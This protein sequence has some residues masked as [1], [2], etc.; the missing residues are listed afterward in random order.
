MLSRH[1]DKLIEAYLDNRL[2]P[3]ERRQVE[4]HIK[5]CAECADRLF[6]AKRL[7][8]QLGP[9]MQAAL[10]QPVLR[11]MLHHEVRQALLEKE[12]RRPFYLN[13]TAPARFLNAVGTVA[14]IG[15]LAIGVFVV[16]QSQMPSP[17]LIQNAASLQTGNTSEE[18]VRI[19]PSPTQST[20]SEVI[21]TP[22]PTGTSLNDIVSLPTPSPLIPIANDE[23]I[24]V[25][26]PLSIKPND[27]I[28]N[29]KPS[30]ALSPELEPEE[31]IALEQVAKSD[32]PGGTIAFALLN[33]LS[34][35]Q[36]YEIHFINPDGTD[37][38]QFPLG[39]VSEPAL[40]PAQIENPL[41]FRAWNEPTSP[42]SIQS[43]DLEAN[44]P[45]SVTYFWEDA[46]P[47]WSPTEN[48]II[49]ASQ[50]EN[51][52]YWRLYT[53]WGDG[54]LEVNLRREGR[55][56]TFAPDGYRFAFESCD[57]AGN[58]CGLWVGDL[59]N[60]E[61]DSK[62]ILAD[63]LA[64]S[65]DWSPVAEDIAYMA[66]PHGD[67]DLYLVKSDGSNIRQLTYDRA[68]EGLPTWSPDGEWLAF[69]SDREEQWGIW[70]LHVETG[71]LYQTITFA[72]DT[73]LPP[74]RPPYNEQEQRQWWDEQLS[75]GPE[76]GN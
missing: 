54:S 63:P 18:I 9:T 72:D 58:P 48:R 53:V 62:P 76:I 25:R 24:A 29:E 13:W 44:L 49:F 52:R 42:R 46:Q 50:R 4:A 33:S 1:I 56:P 71:R 75:W 27:D 57:S 28:N 61:Y 59:E 17:D 7:D 3:E 22:Q 2:L 31:Y 64:K 39:G 16:V 11:P 60:S 41:A 73:W 70:L 5:E 14:I 51:D 34:G 19:T 12:K 40:H 37:H 43:S 47:D 8:S 74:D 6:E 20:L 69:V 38:R 32:L 23:P 67:W 10:G 35:S 66:N 68:N 36:S 15:V 26:R 55:S 30:V 21:L 45:Q 65:P